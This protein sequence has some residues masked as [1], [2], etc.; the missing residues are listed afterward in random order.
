MQIKKRMKG[1]LFIWWNTVSLK[2]NIISCCLVGHDAT[3]TIFDNNVPMITIKHLKRFFLNI[4]LK[5]YFLKSS[6]TQ[7]WLSE[8]WSRGGK[9]FFIFTLLFGTWQRCFKG[10]FA[11]HKTCMRYH[12]ELWKKVT[13][14]FF[15]KMF[16]I[17]WVIK[18]W[19]SCLSLP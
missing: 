8:S 19:I 5:R 13:L 15:D 16:W 11:F 9:Y 12:K 7:P 6:V 18:S 1:L 4:F 10:H 14:T 17:N 3:Y 2:W